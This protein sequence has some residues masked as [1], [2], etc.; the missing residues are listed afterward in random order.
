MDYSIHLVRRSSNRTTIVLWYA[1][2]ALMFGP[3]VGVGVA[4]GLTRSLTQLALLSALVTLLCLAYAVTITVSS[5]GVTVRRSWLLIPLWTRRF[6]LKLSI[7]EHEP[8]ELNQG[9]AILLNDGVGVS[10]T[11]LTRRSQRLAE[12][13]ESAVKAAITEPG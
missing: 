7:E 11:L 4:S 6:S 8:P 1:P 12:V 13:I 2:L 10:A 5:H 9:D 3:I